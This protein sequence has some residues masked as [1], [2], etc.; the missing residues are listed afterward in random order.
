MIEIN[1]TELIEKARTPGAKDKKKRKVTIRGKSID[2]RKREMKEHMKVDKTGQDIWDYRMGT[3][4]DR[5]RINAEGR[6]KDD[7]NRSSET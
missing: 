3:D 4:E 1:T 5:A 6:Q 2:Q 7:R